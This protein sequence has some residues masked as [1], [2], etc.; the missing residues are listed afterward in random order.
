MKTT[1]LSMAVP[2]LLALAACGSKEKTCAAD[3]RLC[4]NTCV[5]V[6]T[7]ALHCGACG[8]A[9]GTGEACQAGACT[10]CAASCTGGQCVAGTCIAPVYAACFNL[11][12]VRGVNGDL[13]PSGAPLATD[14]GPFALARLGNALWVANNRSNTLSKVTFGP[15]ITA[16]QGTGS[17]TLFG[18]KGGF[19]SFDL[20]YVAEHGGLLYVSNA[21]ANT[22]V[23][24]DPARQLV[25]D[26]I[27]LAAGSNP[28]GIAFVGDKAY[29]A[30]RDANQ[31]VV[32]D[33]S[34]EAGC[35]PPDPAA[36][37]CGAGSTCASG[38]TCVHGQCQH[39]FCGKLV[40]KP[41]DVQ[42]FATGIALANPN[43][44]VA[45]GTRVYVTLNDLFDLAFNTVADAH[46][47][48][49]IIDATTDQAI[50]AVDLGASCVDA[51]GAAV[52]GSTLWVGCG[53]FDPSTG[54]GFAPVDLSSATP[55]AGAVVSTPHSPAAVAACGGKVY[56]GAIDSGFLLQLD[57]ATGTV[58]S[59]N[60]CPASPASEISAVACA[61]SP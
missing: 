45:V 39:A 20:E 13:A 30:L 59:V 37:A 25:I 33:V 50:G 58:K 4:G 49:A 6:Q 5:S 16:T 17:I 43:T 27:P 44:V 47:K 52:V 60:L 3:E 11:D 19:G 51:A 34:A 54:A 55:V 18:P 38:L 29:V 22:I 53:S 12:Q 15:P 48:V 2:L 32:I 57:P 31:V 21:A 10:Q 14:Q 24:V 26:E 8:N 61:P 1:T 35:Q 28:N 40:G 23:V 41:I 42:Q 36:P 56:G 9:C 46:G 7:D